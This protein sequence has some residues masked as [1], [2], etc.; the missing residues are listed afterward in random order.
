MVGSGE[1]MVA[2]YCRGSVEVVVAAVPL[3]ASVVMDIL[4]N[5]SKS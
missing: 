3:V 4:E 5:M 1:V 2:G